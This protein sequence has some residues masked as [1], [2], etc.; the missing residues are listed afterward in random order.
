MTKNIFNTPEAMVLLDAGY[1]IRCVEWCEG[2]Y[3]FFTNG[4]TLRDEHLQIIQEI[5]FFKDMK[6]EVIENNEHKSY[7][8]KQDKKI[9]HIEISVIY[10]E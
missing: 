6:W 2:Q 3:I 8:K 7:M 5:C 4:G 9:E 1:K 10:K